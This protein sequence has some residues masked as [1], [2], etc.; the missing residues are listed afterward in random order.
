MVAH[1]HDDF[2][3]D[4]PFQEESDGH[5]VAH[6]KVMNDSIIDRF[7]F[8]FNCILLMR[9]YDFLFSSIH[10]SIRTWKC[11]TSKFLLTRLFR[12]LCRYLF[13]ITWARYA[14]LA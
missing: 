2:D 1:V 11:M 4:K 13:G 5:L 10:V 12:L 14:L 8:V 7:F 3:T 9:F 6:V